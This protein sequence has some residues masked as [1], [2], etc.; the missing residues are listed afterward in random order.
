M[1]ASASKRRKVVM[2][3]RASN[4]GKFFKIFPQMIYGKKQKVTLLIKRF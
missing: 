1:T 4:S 3:V 2:G